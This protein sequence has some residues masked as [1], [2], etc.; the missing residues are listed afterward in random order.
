MVCQFTKVHRKVTNWDALRSWADQHQISREE[1]NRFDHTRVYGE[2]YE[3]VRKLI[4]SE[5]QREIVVCD[6]SKRWWKKKEEKELRKRAR[7]NKS[8]KKE[9]QRQIKEAKV[10]CWER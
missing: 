9:L 5:W 4:A 6:R 1:A 8:A 7:K 3:E 2:A 10:E